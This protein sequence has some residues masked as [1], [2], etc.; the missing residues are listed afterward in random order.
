[1]FLIAKPWILQEKGHL[2]K[3]II[4]INSSI[5]S[6]L[7]KKRKRKKDALDAQVD[8]KSSVC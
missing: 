5:S 6:F 4:L 2:C 1:M 3:E 7:P 8:N